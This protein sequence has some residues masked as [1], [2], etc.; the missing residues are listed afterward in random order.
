ME[1]AAHIPAPLGE[2]RPRP[3]LALERNPKNEVCRGADR[4]QVGGSIRT[5]IPR[6]HHGPAA[7]DDPK[8]KRCGFGEEVRKSGGQ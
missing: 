4:G 2:G 5:V 7:G 6:R 3:G 8:D 1:I